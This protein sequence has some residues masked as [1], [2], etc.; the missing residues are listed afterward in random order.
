VVA[1]LNS[2]YWNDP[3]LLWNVQ[4][5][6]L[7]PSSAATATVSGNTLTIDPQSSFAGAFYV[8][9]AASDGA[10]SASQQ[11]RVDVT[12]SAP[13]LSAIANQTMSHT[14]DTLAI[15]LGAAD[16]DSDT[17][18]YTTQVFT[19][20]PVAQTAYDLDQQV[21]LR[22]LGTYCQN[23]YGANEKWMGGANGLS[24]GI[25]P[26]GRVIAWYGSFVTSPVVATLT[27]AYWND[28]SLLWNA[29]APA[30]VP[31]SAATATVSGN[32]LTIDPQSS[33]AGAFYVRVAASD[34]AASASQQ[35]R[36]E[37]TAVDGSAESMSSMASETS[38]AMAAAPVVSQAA[39]EAPVNASTANPSTPPLPMTMQSSDDSL[40]AIVATSTVNVVLPEFAIGNPAPQ[41]KAA[42]IDIATTVPFAS[43][44]IMGSDSILYR[45]ALIDTVPTGKQFKS[46]AD[47]KPAAPAAKPTASFQPYDLE[48]D[49]LNEVV[50]LLDTARSAH[51]LSAIE[52][53]YEV[54][55]D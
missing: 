21:G 7:V 22:Y 43:S 18:V 8:R 45:T 46:A 12:N 42:P 34:G 26:D 48:E 55:V 30:L 3:S 37:V 1:T 40:A 53:F 28:P 29:Q 35:F 27:S 5:P 9:V 19:T 17:I 52:R 14:Q 51:K 4:A 49:I 50:A 32:T 11:F 44:G 54:L 38:V 31:S 47:T 23:L 39:P 20:D 6:A 10:A 33:F 16:A 25:L 13:T 41:A 2:A 15:S 36:V 24:Y